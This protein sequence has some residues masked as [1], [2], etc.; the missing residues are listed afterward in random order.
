MRYLIDGYNL[1]HAAGSLFGKVGPH[2]LEKG[3]ASLLGRIAAAHG[4]RAGD[5]TVVFDAR[6]HPRNYP[7]EQ[8]VQGII[9]LFAVGEEADDAIERLIRHE[10]APKLLTVVSSD[11]RIKDAARRKGCHVLGCQEYLDHLDSLRHPAR[12]PEAPA[13]EKPD[14]AD[15]L[16]DA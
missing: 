6:R 5:V 10:S 4:P 1:A 16:A 9:V 14:G 11:R 3:R 8:T 2:G 7:T 15:P 12:Q 13:A